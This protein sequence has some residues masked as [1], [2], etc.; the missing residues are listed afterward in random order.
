VRETYAALTTWQFEHRISIEEAEGAKPA[1]KIADVSLV[2]AAA[3][4]AGVS[5]QSLCADRCRLESKTGSGAT[6]LLVRDGTNT[7]LYSSARP[8]Y[9]KG[10]LVRDVM[11]SAPGA[12]LFG[13]HIEPL[14]GLEEK[15]SGEATVAGEDTINIDGERRECYVVETSL[16]TNGISVDGR[17]RVPTPDSSL[18]SLPS[19]YYQLLQ[20]YGMFPIQL[21]YM[22]PAGAALPR[23]RFW[24]DKQRY[25]V[26]RRV[27][28]Q[29]TQKYSASPAQSQT[30]IDVSLR[31][32]DTFSAA[33]LGDK[34]Q[35]SLFT[36]QPPAGSHE[37]PNIRASSSTPAGKELVRTNEIGA[38]YNELPSSL[39]ITIET[40]LAWSPGI[41]ADVNQDRMKATP[42]VA[43]SVGSDDRICTVKVFSNTATSGCGSFVSM[44]TL[45]VRREANRRI[46]VFNLPKQELTANGKTAQLEI[47]VWTGAGW[48]RNPTSADG[49]HFIV[50]FSGN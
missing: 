22:A 32:V 4:P 30:M 26:L 44:A 50:P 16:K 3:G 27:T 42:D 33:R 20:L 37:V 12:F 39:T 47:T 35:R 31:A 7:W 46:A 43:Y 45:Q 17:G 21:P 18:F 25:L 10:A 9:M 11:M 24:I 48:Y 15:D 29:T 6:T 23:V 2:T 40:P 34:V 28:T 13:I 14:G 41:T 36:F 49:Y 38:Y 5:P 1:V 19:T 8:E